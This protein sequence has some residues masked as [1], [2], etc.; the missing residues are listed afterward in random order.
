MFENCIKGGIIVFVGVGIG[1]LNGLHDRPEL[2][3]PLVL[4]GLL[5]V[6]KDD[7]HNHGA[8]SMVMP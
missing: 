8:V 2:S 4:L 7:E 1:G 5:N 6:G 3:A